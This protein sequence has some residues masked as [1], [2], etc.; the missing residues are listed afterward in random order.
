MVLTRQI[1]EAQHAAEGLAYLAGVAQ[2]PGLAG[3]ETE[4]L[5]CSGAVVAPTILDVA[6]S[7]DVAL[8]VMCSRGYT[9][10]KRW[11]LGSVA[12]QVA[13]KTPVPALVLHADGGK[14]LDL[15]LG[16]SRPVRVLVPLDGSSQAEKALIPA[17]HLSAA[18]SASLQGALHLTQVIRLPDPYE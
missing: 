4:T 3:V 7:H 10:F 8:I 6:Y 16:E 18:L 1:P 9:G 14:P 2:L 5:V 11:V 15:H 13:R 12:Q 17:A